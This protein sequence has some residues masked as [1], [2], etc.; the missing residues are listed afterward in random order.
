MVNESIKMAI[1]DSGLKKNYIA[2][3]VGL[4]DSIL[5]AIINGTRKISADEFFMFCRV[6]NKTPDELYYYQ[7][8]QTIGGQTQRIHYG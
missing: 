7:R 4:S 8:K 1:S 2:Q 5:S 3:Q 6:L